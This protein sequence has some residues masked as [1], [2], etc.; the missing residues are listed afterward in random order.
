M[1][2]IRLEGDAGYFTNPQA[3]ASTAKTV[4]DLIARGYNIHFVVSHW[5]KPWPTDFPNKD[6]LSGFAQFAGTL[7]AATH[8]PGRVI[9]EIWNEPNDIGDQFWPKPRKGV[10]EAFMYARILTEATEAIH[11]R[12]P[13]AVVM[14]GGL[15]TY[16]GSYGPDML[17]E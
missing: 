16:S 7:A 13:G 17:A 12:A 2:W 4:D 11:M 8:R 14:S 15:F 6:F 5:L 10:N 1:K 9:F 3:Y